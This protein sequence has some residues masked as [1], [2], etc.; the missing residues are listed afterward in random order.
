MKQPDLRNMFNKASKSICTSSVVASPD[1]LSP[2]PISLAM[3][4][5][6]NIEED[7]EPADGGDIQMEYSSN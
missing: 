3:K 6:E 1:P 5:Q 2:A 7:R 4:T